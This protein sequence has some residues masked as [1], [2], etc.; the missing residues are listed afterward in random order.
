MLSAGHDVNL[1]AAQEQHDAVQDMQKKKKGFL[2]SKTTTTHDEWHY[3]L[4]VG[5]SLDAGSVQIKAG[6]DIAVVGSTLL[7]QQDARLVA[8]NDVAIVA[9]QDQQR[10][11]QQRPEKVRLQ[12]QL[13]RRR[14]QPRLWQVAQQQRQQHREHH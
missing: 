4:A 3:S 13:L 10:G 6:N 2:S 12:R 7:A 9:A 1:L 8:G 14:G 11:A 5:T